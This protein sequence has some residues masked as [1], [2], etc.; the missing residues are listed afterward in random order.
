MIKI[1]I[2]GTHCV[3][4]TTLALEL[5]TVIADGGTS[6]EL[7]AEVARGCPFPI[8]EEA[9]QEAFYWILA[10][11]LQLEVEKSTHADVL[12][13]DRSVLDNFVYYARL[14]GTTGEEAEAFN[15][16]CK[17]WMKTYDLIVR[18][19][20]SFSLRDDR[21]RSLNIR[22]QHEIDELFDQLVES[23]YGSDTHPMYVRGPLSARD[24]VKIMT[25]FLND[26][27]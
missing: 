4:K 2:I 17:S 10:R 1:A 26:S 18:L 24:I 5:A 11:Q 14:F 25:P 19:P 15:T 27:K 3:G 6:V 8:N 22:F 16:F 7:L 20:I 21:Y 23:E 12:I 9:T 13:C